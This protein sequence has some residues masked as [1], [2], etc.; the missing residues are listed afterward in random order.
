MTTLASLSET[1][2]W[3]LPN[4]FVWSF[5]WFSVFTFGVGGWWYKNLFLGG[6]FSGLMHG[7]T[8][9]TYCIL[10]FQKET[11]R[12]FLFLEGACVSPDDSL[13]YEDLVLI[14]VSAAYFAT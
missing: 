8:M 1:V 5:G 11:F 12:D 9:I 3:A 6:S 4:V 2:F 14:T 13:S 7:L 10:E